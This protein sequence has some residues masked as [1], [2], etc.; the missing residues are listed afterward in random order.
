[1][2]MSKGSLEEINETVCHV[3]SSPLSP[4]TNQAILDREASGDL[5]KE[6]MLAYAETIIEKKM[7]ARG[8][9]LS[10]PSTITSPTSAAAIMDVSNNNIP[11]KKKA[12]EIIPSD[13]AVAPE[14]K[15][16][17]KAVEEVSDES[18][19]SDIDF[20]A[21]KIIEKLPPKMNNNNNLSPALSVT[22]TNSSSDSSELQAPIKPSTVESIPA[23]A[24]AKPST[25]PS[26]LAISKTTR[27]RFNQLQQHRQQHQLLQQQ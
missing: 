9:P 21:P 23:T 14:K 16:A 27:S 11:I 25:A 2:I 26:K 6:V 24:A 1:M 13:K 19:A 5:A 18:Q 8:A 20:E 7:A 4:T 15:L 12:A 17:P 22:S 10:P 3:S